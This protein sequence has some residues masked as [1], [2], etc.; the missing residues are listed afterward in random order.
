MRDLLTTVYQLIADGALPMPESTH[1]PLSDAATAIRVIS[2]AQHTGKLVL[3]VPHTGRRRVTVSP[4]HARV[5]RRDGAYLITGGLGGLGLFLAEKM[6][7]AGCGRI[8][9]SSRSQPTLKALETIERIRAIG[10][11][12]AVECGDIAQPSTAQRL[13]ATA[14]ATGLPVRGVLHAAAVVDDATLTN[15]TDELIERDWAPKVYGAWNLH[16]ATADQPLDWYC[17]FSSA[18]ALVGSPGQG[19]YAAANSWLDGFTHWRRAQ[20]LPATAIAWGPWAQIGRATALAESSDVAIRPNE[21]AYAF[22][23]LLRHDR[24]YT[25]LRADH[26]QPVVDGL[27]RAEPVRRSV[28]LHRTKPNGHKQTAGRARQAA[29]GRVAHPAAASYLRSGQPDSP[30][31]R[32]SRP[33]A[34]RV[35]PGLTG[36]PR[37]TYPHRDRNGNTHLIHRHH[38]HYHSRFGGAAVRKAGAR[39]SRLTSRGGLMELEDRTHPLTAAQ[40][41]IWLAQETG[42]FSTEWQLGL[43]AKIEGPVQREPLEWAIRRALREAEP[44][45]ATFFEEDGEV[46][47]RTIDEPDVDLAF[48]DL[49]GSY[50]P[51][52]EAYEIAS[53]IQ[54]TPMPFTGP[55]FKFA[56]FQTRRDEFYWFTCCHHIV[57]D[58]SGIALIGLRIATIYSAIVSG[59]PMPPAFF[60]SLEDLISSES[61][62]EASTDYLE[63]QAYWTENLPSESGS[64]HAFPEAAGERGPYRASAPVRLDPVV[65]RRVQELSELGNMPQ[66]SVIT[67]ACAL[68]VRGWCAEGSE[69]VLDF[70]VSRRVHLESK[71]LPGM[72]AGVVPLVLRVSPESSVADFCQHVDARIREALQHQRFPVQALERKARFRGQGQPAQRVSVNFLPSVFTL[73]FGGVTASASYTNSGLVGGFGLFFSGLG[74]QLLFGTE[75]AGQPFSNVDVSELAGRLQQV[76]VAMTAD[77]GR[78]LSS[79]H[80]FD[81]NECARLDGWGNRAALTKPAPLAVSIPELLSGQV[82]R[83]PEAAAVTFDGRS[84]TYRELD[85]AANRLAHLLTGLGAGPGQ[86]VALLFTRSPEAVIGMLAVLKSGAA[87]LPID[88]AVPAARSEFMLADA[89]PIAAITT[90]AL[91]DR[92][93]G[94][95]LLVIDVNDPQI[96]TYPGTALPAPAADDIAYLI[97]TSGT[98]GVPKGVAVTHRNVTQLLEALDAYLPVA[99]VWTQCHTYGFDTSVWE[100]WG[101]LLHGGRLVVVPESVAGSPND[102]HALLVAEQVSVLTQTP[103]A[104]GVLSPEGLGSTALVV[105]GEACPAEVVDRWAPGRVMINAYGPTETTMVVMLSAPLTAGSD[106]VPIG[107]PVPG[108]ALFV[109]DGWLRPVPVDV[110]GE[111]YVAG[112][113]VGVGYWRR[114]GL[115]ASRFVACPFGPAG[116]RMYRTG[117]LVRWAPDGQLQYLGRAD[118]QVKIRGYRI[119]LGE[120]QAALAGLDGVEQAVVV[121]REDHAGDKRLVGYVTGTAD[122]VG[123]RASLAERLPAYMVP[124]AIVAMQTL[125]LTVNGKLDSRALPAPE[126]KDVDRYRA[127]GSAVEEILAGIYAQVLGLERVGVDDSFFDLGGDS[128][129]AMRVM[130]AINKSLDAGLSLRAL[131]DA[132]TVALLAPLL[133][134][135]GT[136]A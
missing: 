39:G 84:M 11:D 54:R 74:D 9:L 132:P 108:A 118:E 31:Q 15:I 68:L 35:R 40:L 46:L 21:G 64:D 67:A 55:L 136:G 22:E 44:V 101:A 135:N 130:A 124:A 88:P 42:R 20:G 56:L 1:Y 71:T 12:V 114:T 87:Y 38:H 111:L 7:A 33:A 30:S 119:E 79:I 98:T 73:D 131:F 128:L 102:F 110:A 127:P 75:G 61:G 32:R 60:G 95:D 3:D 57:I 77:P 104:V 28:P 62:Y 6:A 5:F 59:A 43:F 36:R 18:A 51:V 92:L 117:D 24:A 78:R 121:A 97:Y 41:D 85:E 2:G 45:R 47:Q 125:P 53:S 109:L 25:W 90:A 8:V 120:V 34:V 134:E 63:D 13:V 23:A 82:S 26:G 122:P 4:S 80:V 105:A 86:C 96:Q 107:A 91:A 66:S 126:Y 52:Q 115:S 37:T 100:T 83:A 17:S 70:P 112:R 99:G 129:S 103:S 27:R 113:G 10:A 58:A 65:L 94:C 76:L 16:T 72:V 81:A 89:A 106:V 49:S 133:N 48:Y 14:I 123:T 93:H 19:A 69:V 29:S 50:Q 116:T